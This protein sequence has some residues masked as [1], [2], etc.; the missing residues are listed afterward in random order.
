MDTSSLTPLQRLYLPLIDEVFF[1]Q[2]VLNEQGE[3]VSHTDVV[4]ALERELVSYW[5]AIGYSGGS[6]ANGSFGQFFFVV[7]KTERGKLRVPKF[8]HFSESPLKIFVK[9]QTN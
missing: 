3:L 7:L 4:N 2:A 6:F 1:K 8:Q 9:L 5:S